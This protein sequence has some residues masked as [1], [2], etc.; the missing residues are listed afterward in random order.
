MQQE[1]LSEQEIF[2][3]RGEFYDGFIGPWI[4]VLKVVK[5][6]SQKTLANVKTNFQLFFTFN[7]KKAKEI[8]AKNRDRVAAI[9]KDTEAILKEMPISNDFAAAAFIMNPAA[10]L[11]AAHGKDFVEGSVDYLKGAGFGDF[12]PEEGNYEAEKRKQDDKGPLGKALQALEQIFLIAHASPDGDILV[13]QDQEETAESPTEESVVPPDLLLAALEETGDLKKLEDLKSKFLNSLFKGP[14]SIETL[15]N[16]A[17]GQIVFMKKIA[18]SENLEQLNTALAEFKKAVPEAEMGEI[19][20]LPQTLQKDAENIAK[21]E[22]A[23]S[24]IRDQFLEE[25]GVSDPK[26]EDYQ[27]IDAQELEVYINKIAFGQALSSVQ[28]SVNETIG[29]IIKFTESA[30]DENVREAFQDADAEVLDDPELQKF[31]KEAKAQINR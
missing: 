26:E 21:N 10:Y 25:K 29:N 7:G 11:V 3:N 31:I 12:L 13:E 1:L 9:N 27:K 6:E 28:G 8:L 19:D 17:N 2:W 15:V 18:E 14:D 20:K 23:M 30:I 24:E 5:N 4:N 16:L 22:K